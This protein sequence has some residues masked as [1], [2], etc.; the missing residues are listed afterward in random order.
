MLGI[1]GVLKHCG[2]LV[3]SPPGLHNWLVRQTFNLK[4]AGSSPASG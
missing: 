4:V 1:D 3:Y 2:G